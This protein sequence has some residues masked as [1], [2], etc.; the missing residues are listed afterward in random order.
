MIDQRSQRELQLEAHNALLQQ[1]LLAAQMDHSLV[2]GAVIR[3]QAVAVF[4]SVGLLGAIGALAIL[5]G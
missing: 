3:L 1:R 2:K 4:S 5:M